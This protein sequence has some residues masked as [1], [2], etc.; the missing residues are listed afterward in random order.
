MACFLLVEKNAYN[1]S[2]LYELFVR[3]NCMFVFNCFKE[4]AL[5][6]KGNFVYI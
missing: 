3:T 1:I 2:F 4:K 6:F 5:L